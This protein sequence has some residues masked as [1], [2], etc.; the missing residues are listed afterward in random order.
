MAPTLAYLLLCQ[1][2]LYTAVASKKECDRPLLSVGMDTD[3]LQRVYS[4]GDQVVVSC[5]RGF[6]PSPG[7]RTII[8]T[9]RGDWTKTK[10]KCLTK[11]CSS[12]EPLDHGD[13]D[14][15]DITYQ[16]TITYTCHEG[17]SLHGARTVEC[18]ADGQWSMQKPKC[19]P[20]TCGLPPI[21]T[22]GK[23]TYDRRFSGN[24]T[25][26]GFGVNYE[27]LPP[28]ALIG[29]ERGYCS[30]NGKWT[31]PPECKLVT[32]P[33][34]TNITN[35]YMTSDVNREHGYKE[36][37]RYGCNVDYMLDGPVEIECLSTGDWSEQPT[38]RAPCKIGITK[39][40][41][42]YNGRKMWMKDF[43]QKMFSHKDIISF[44]CMDKNK[45]CTYEMS[46][47]CL[48]GNLKIPECFEDPR[49]IDQFNSTSLPAELVP[50]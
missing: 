32:C 8:C 41:I 37:V 31:E 17:Y 24:T 11:S 16:S 19:L 35:G 38:C 40:R 49:L 7:L 28:L 45:K 22:Y 14:F 42:R 46:G 6:T 18:L 12:P 2:V 33:P 13:M 1:L 21:P 34:P 5:K 36:T 10:L 25:M 50:C 30:A 48:D 39:G 15:E 43:Q 26:F 23:I 9:A 29:N 3:G 44:Y 4:P 27:C 20:V 47:Q